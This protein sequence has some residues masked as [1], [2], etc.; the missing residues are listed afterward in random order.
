ME[1]IF[2]NCYECNKNFKL[3][4]RNIEIDKRLDEYLEIQG[5]LVQM[6]LPVEIAQKIIYI[7]NTLA[8]CKYCFKTLCYNHEISN[9]FLHKHEYNVYIVCNTCLF[10]KK[11]EFWIM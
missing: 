11:S 6:T 5:I 9:A 7:A 4:K 2:T 10:K 3:K 8:F 1:S